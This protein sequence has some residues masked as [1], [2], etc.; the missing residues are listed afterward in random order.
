MLNSVA[1]L[2][3]KLNGGF[4]FFPIKKI[5]T[6]K[7][8]YMQN[9]NSILES[10]TTTTFFPSIVMRLPTSAGA[11]RQIAQSLCLTPSYVMS[12]AIVS[13]PL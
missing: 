2:F 5:M 11:D 9:L 10:E 3:G 7:K 12:L 6:R 8:I 4:T 13:C 1:N